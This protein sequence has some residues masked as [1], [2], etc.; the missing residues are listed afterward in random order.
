MSARIRFTK[1]SLW[2]SLF[3]LCI[4]IL[5][6]H[7]QQYLSTLAGEVSD[8]TGATIAHACSAFFHTIA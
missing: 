3:V 2:L 5:P 8:P 1:K 6:L 4:G 7:A